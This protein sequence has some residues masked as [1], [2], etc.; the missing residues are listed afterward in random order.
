M[1]IKKFQIDVLLLRG[2]MST[3]YAEVKRNLLSRLII[4]RRMGIISNLRLLVGYI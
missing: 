2:L 1:H 3:V 4:L